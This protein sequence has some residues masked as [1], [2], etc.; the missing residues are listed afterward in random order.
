MSEPKSFQATPEM[1]AVGLS[2]PDVETQVHHV[3]NLLQTQGDAALEVVK[4]LIKLVKLATARDMF[5]VMAQLQKSTVD[6]Q[7]LI[8]AIKEEFELS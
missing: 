3:L 8:T 7:A 4:G 1:A 2:W 5:G 6:I